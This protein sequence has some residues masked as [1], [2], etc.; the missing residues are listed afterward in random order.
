VLKLKHSVEVEVEAEV[1]VGFL[2]EVE[3]RE[4]KF[5]S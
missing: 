4:L 5:E 1:E 2:V 3:F